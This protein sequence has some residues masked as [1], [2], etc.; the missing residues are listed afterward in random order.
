[1]N[2]QLD[3]LIHSAGPFGQGFAFTGRLIPN[4]YS[5]FIFTYIIYTFGWIAGALLAVLVILFLIRISHIAFYVKSSYGK[6][7]ICGF[8][9]IFAVQ[10][11]WNILMNLSLAPIAAMGLPFISYGNSQFVV[12]MAVIG[13]ISNIYKQRNAAAEKLA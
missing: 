13:L 4:I 11:L 1:M 12:N 10:F 2:V 6:F 5:D 9:A 7:L 8:V 3:K